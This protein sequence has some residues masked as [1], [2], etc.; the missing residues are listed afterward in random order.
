M[1]A[2]SRWQVRLVATALCVSTS[3][4]L[5]TPAAAQES[6]PKPSAGSVVPDAPPRTTS[7][8]ALELESAIPTNVAGLEL[9]TVSF[10]GADVAAGADDDDP[11]AGLELVVADV[12]MTME[13]LLLASGTADDGERFM[14]ILAARLGGVPA[15]DFAARLTPLLL[16][17]TSDTPLVELAV[18]DHTVTQVGPGTGL[19]G[20]ALVYIVERGDTAWYIVTDEGSLEDTLAALP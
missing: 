19:T 18:G 15:A 8:A 1:R 4:A 3:I 20:D 9:T 11:I 16:E 2:A 5:A 7:E 17:T 6:S 13:D 10:S 14:G 12:G